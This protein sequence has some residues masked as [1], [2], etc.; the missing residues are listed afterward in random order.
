MDGD[1]TAHLVDADVYMVQV[2]NATNHTVTVPRKSKL[3]KIVEIEETMKDNQY[4]LKYD[5]D[6]D[7]K[8]EQDRFLVPINPR[9]FGN[10]VRK[11]LRGKFEYNFSSAFIYI[12]GSYGTKS[13]DAPALDTFLLSRQNSNPIWPIAALSRKK[14]MRR[15]GFEG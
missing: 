14:S 2:R 7:L 5:E 4:L 12:N 13:D 3:G 11:V 10:R 8:S 9:A 6:G 1:V 15:A